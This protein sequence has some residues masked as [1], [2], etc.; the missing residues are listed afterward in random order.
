MTFRLRLA[1]TARFLRLRRLADAIEPK[2]TPWWLQRPMGY[3]EHSAVAQEPTQE[4][5]ER[6]PVF[7]DVLLSQMQYTDE[8]KR[9]ALVREAMLNPDPELAGKAAAELHRMIFEGR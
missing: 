6:L 5:A 9:K 1:R 3:R 4:A 7:E 2:L 8:Q